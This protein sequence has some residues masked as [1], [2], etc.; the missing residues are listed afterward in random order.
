MYNFKIKEIITNDSKKSIIP[1][2]INIIIG[3]NNSGK[4]QFLKDIR[5]ILK[6]NNSDYSPIVIKKLNYELPKNFEEFNQRYNLNDRIF[7]INNNQ[8]YIKDYSGI[9]NQEIEIDNSFSSYLDL[10]N[11][12]VDSNWKI[13]L[14]YMIK[15]FH[16]DIL[17]DP[18]LIHEMDLPLDSVVCDEKYIVYE[19]DGKKHKIPISGDVVPMIRKAGESIPEFISNYGSIFFNYL[20]TEEKLLMCK[21]QRNYGYIDYQTNILSEIKFELKILEEL[22]KYTLKLFKKD[23]YL[24]KYTNGNRICFRVGKNFDFIRNSNRND[25]LSEKRLINFNMLDNEGDGL[26]SFVTT[27]LSLKMNNKNILLLDEPE[28]FLHPPLARQ[29]GELIASSVTDGKQIFVATHSSDIIRGILGKTK[30]VN[31]IRITRNKNKNIIKKIEEKELKEALLNGFLPTNDFLNGLFSE[32][33]Y[34]CEASRD[35]EFYQAL[36]DKI[37]FSDPALF[38]YGNGKDTLNKLSSIYDKYN[39]QNFRIYDFDALKY[40]S[41][42]NVIKEKFSNNKRNYY[43]GLVKKLELEFSNNKDNYHIGGINAIKDNSL[44][45]EIENMLDDLKKNGIIFLKSGELES[46]L[47]KEGIHYTS[48]NKERWLKDAIKYINDSSKNK[49]KQTDIYKWLFKK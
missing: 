16:N 27:F 34:I 47:I 7:K 5:N 8:Y 30:D 10:S 11:V 21:I 6:G 18:Q 13:Q 2:S 42:K 29:L 15:N 37:K 32:K 17:E 48:N 39:I 40:Q 22:S 45:C 23:I 33:V 41:F 44:K 38:M 26:K 24:D 3:P 9:Y 19:K 31:I 28:S 4:S 46:T 1:K 20:G 12:N 25:I 14:D 49:I 43:I 36:H 35:V